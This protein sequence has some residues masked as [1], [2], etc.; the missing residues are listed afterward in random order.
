LHYSSDPST[1]KPL[2]EV[3]PSDSGPTIQAFNLQK[4]H[5]ISG[6]QNLLI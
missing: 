2:P 6:P 3:W 1:K 4:H 5:T